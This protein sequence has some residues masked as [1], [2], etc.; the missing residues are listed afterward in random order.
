MFYVV[1]LIEKN[2]NQDK[3]MKKNNKIFIIEYIIIHI[4]YV[5]VKSTR[6][7]YRP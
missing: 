6:R 5:N 2:N 3:K 7:E 4:I 1:Y